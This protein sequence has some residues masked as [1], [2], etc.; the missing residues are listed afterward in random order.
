MK[1][2][3]T[4]I[5]FMFFALATAFAAKKQNLEIK[6]INKWLP[7]EIVD[8]SGKISQFQS[9][10]HLSFFAKDKR[11][12]K[13]FSILKISGQGKWDLKD[14]LLTLVFDLNPL[15][16]KVDSVCYEVI[17]DGPVLIYYQD[18]K[19]LTR[20][21][22]NQLESEKIISQFKIISCNESQ[23]ILENKKGQ[24]I[25]KAGQPPEA[26]SI[27]ASGFSF[28]SLYRGVIGLLTILFLAWLFS[29]NRK[30]IAWRV[31]GIGLLVQIVIAVSV[32]KIPFMQDII[33]LIGQM[34]IKVLEFTKVGSE[35]LFGGFLD[36]STYGY[37]FAFQILP[38]IIF[39]SALT[40]IF[41]Y[42]G[43]IQKIVYG[44]A[45]LLTKA[46]KISG[47]EGLSAAGNI[48]LG[49]TESP[50]LIKEYL[51]KMNRSEIMLVMVGGM[52]TIAGG[53][54]AIYIG[55]L[56]GDDPVER[57]IFARH[58]IT[59]SVMAAPGAVVAA[60]MLMPQTEPIKSEIKITRDKIGNNVL[61]AISN[62]TTQGIRLAV[63]VGA[64][65]LVFLALIAMLNFIFMKVG[66]WTHLNPIIAD[67][68][69]GQYKSF[70]LQF[71]LGYAFT[72]IAWAI[73]VPAADMTLVAQLFGEKIILNEMIAYVSMKDLIDGMA[74]THNKSIIISTYILCGFA[75]FSS[76]GIQLGGIGALAPGKRKMLSQLGFRAL[77]GGA[78]ASLL[79]ATIVGMILG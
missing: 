22:K 19:E 63:N 72:P 7:Q 40:S 29:A 42:Y 35:F 13:E 15:N 46:L 62:G 34:F 57:L 27:S 6:I 30:A 21:N 28:T 71:I 70:S 69:N 60:K 12:A 41:F 75:N 10:D 58:L 11:F 68:T 1:R 39:F 52:A 53:V 78:L 45:W 76:I 64:M 20:L 3:N 56:G 25:F 5:V 9:T 55:L 59:A 77:I 2:K 24:Q 67:I 33:G 50:L 4:L 17:Q 26:M 61:E 38:T 32:L 54:L 44:L 43:I 16:V 79:S 74:F 66:G 48:F 31:V 73:G 37:I 51:D 18:G 14:S 49:Q 47:A 36:T 65:L 8:T 23:L